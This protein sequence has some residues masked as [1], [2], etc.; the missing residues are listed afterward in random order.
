MGTT[1]LMPADNERLVKLIRFFDLT[2]T[3]LQ[4]K[5]AELA[6]A[7]EM[8]VQAV[9][10]FVKWAERYGIL[11][12]TR[13]ADGFA[14]GRVP[15]TYTLM[16]GVNDWLAKGP[17]IVAAMRVRPPVVK[18]TK[19]L[20]STSKGDTEMAQAVRPA[21]AELVREALADAPPVEPLEP[22]GP[23]P[24]DEVEHWRSIEG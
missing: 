4:I 2:G 21:A 9:S 24:D 13:T 17:D 3:P 11:E 18:E 20:P 23:M 15:N 10:R 14:G 6:E 8:P 1:Y 22:M 19:S 7:L 12:V 16:I 5:N